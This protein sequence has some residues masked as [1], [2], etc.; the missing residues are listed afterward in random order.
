[1]N[2]TE[3]AIDCNHLSDHPVLIEFP[4]NENWALHGNALAPA[5]I[6]QN[7]EHSTGESTSRPVGHQ[8]ARDFVDHGFADAADIRSHDRD[9]GRLRLNHDIGEVLGS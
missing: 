7:T 8:Q 2:A 6:I 3:F 5:R 1:M 4:G 9:S